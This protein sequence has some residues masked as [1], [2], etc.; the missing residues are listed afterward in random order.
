MELRECLKTRKSETE[1]QVGPHRGTAEDCV[2]AVLQ[3]MIWEDHKTV[4][5]SGGGLKVAT[6]L[7]CL[8]A[9]NVKCFDAV[10][11]LSAGSLIA[12]L[13]AAGNSVAGI[14]E[15]FLGI[16]QSNFFFEAC[17]FERLLAG[18]LPM[19]PQKL[20][21][22]LDAWLLECSVPL[23][24]TLGWL[25]Q[26]R[27]MTFGC[28]AAELETGRV[29]LFEAT[30]WPDV[31]IV[32]ALMASMAIPGAVEPVHVAGRSYIDLG[33]TNNTP[34]SF[35]EAKSGKLLAFSTCRQVE[36]PFCNDAQ[37]CPAAALKLKTSFLMN[38][39]L[40]S[41]DPQRVTVVEVPPPP[42]DVHFFRVSAEEMHSLFRQGRML[43][44]SRIL[45]RELGG[46]LVLFCH[47]FLEAAR[48][49]QTHRPMA[50][51]HAAGVLAWGRGAAQSL[52]DVFGHVARAAGA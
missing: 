14:E 39:E 16:A 6:F 15:K 8:E 22:M 7:G 37:A 27:R 45:R 17:S 51:P 18:R 10:Y 13:L 50:E 46:L 33:I 44:V 29:V 38:A 21:A 43:V 52:L 24:A 11:G 4:F 47:G 12:C 36:L 5:F 42:S 35:L 19:D 1:P 25:A 9:I 26:H 30:T 2:G 41:A 23:G 31:K 28:F 48:S 49:R 20:R 40:C 34:I 3:K 32:D